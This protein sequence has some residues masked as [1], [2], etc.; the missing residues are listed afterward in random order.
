[1]SNQVKEDSKDNK[2]NILLLESDI[3]SSNETL[4]KSKEQLELLENSI[5]EEK[6]TEISEKLSQVET[7]NAELEKYKKISLKLKQGVLEL[8]SKLSSASSILSKNKAALSEIS[9]KLDIY[10]LNKCPHCLSDLTDDKHS[11][12]KDA[13]IEKQR[14]FTEKTPILQ[15]NIEDLESSKHELVNSYDSNKKDVSK[16]ELDIINLQEAIESLKIKD[17]SKQ[18]NALNNIISN[19]QSKIT[20][21]TE[22]LEKTTKKHE[23]FTDMLDFLSE[24]GV[25]QRL[26]DKVMPIL[27]SKILTISKKLDFKFSFEFDSQFNP[28]IA[29]L[30]EEIAPDSLS[31]GEQKKM[32]LIVLL[33]M[34]ELIKMKNHQINVLFLDEI[35]SSL[36]KDSIY[37]TIE[38]LK[39]FSKEHGLTV[40]VISHDPL[41]EEL[42]HKKISIEK[43]NFFSEMTL[44]S[45]TEG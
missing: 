32:N 2:S 3:E 21:S 18:T 17:N 13:I 15:K 36:D 35:F 9:K 11:K 39:D 41:P 6:T 45:A 42:F 26:M 8:N 30:G 27:N 23:I 31:T 43:T 20:D 4:T 7:K 44:T 12:I 1:M 40:F 29:H 38:I 25:K 37:K 14:I 16:I 22:K 24:S 33:A 5:S 28:I 10:E 34:L 19:I